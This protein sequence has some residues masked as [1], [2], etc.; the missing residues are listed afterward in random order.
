MADS[1]VYSCTAQNLAGVIVA[2]AT[3]TILGNNNF[4]SLSKALNVKIVLIMYVLI[5]RFL[6]R[7]TVLRKTDG[8]QR[9]NGRRLDRARMHGQRLSTSEIIVAEER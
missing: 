6:F 5:T 2:N 7:N 4:L 1:G 3:L 8:E 9:N